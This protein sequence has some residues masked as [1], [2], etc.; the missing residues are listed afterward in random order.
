MW[1]HAGAIV[2]ILAFLLQLILIAIGGTRALA[3]MEAAILAQ[4]NAHQK[5]TDDEFGKVRNEFGETGKALREKINQ[6]ELFLRDNYVRRD[7]FYKVNDDTQ[8]SIKTL[9]DDLKSWLERLE[10]KIDSKT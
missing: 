7:S 10:T 2:A 4:L 1:E 6:V 8:A 3:K 5:D 9:G